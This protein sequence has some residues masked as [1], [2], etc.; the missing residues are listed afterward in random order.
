MVPLDTPSAAPGSRRTR[1][2]AVIHAELISLR[3]AHSG[4]DAAYYGDHPEWLIAVDL[5]SH[6]DA[7]ALTRSNY[8]VV[9][10]RLR[11]ADGNEETWCEESSSHWAVGWTANFAVAPGSGAE[12]VLRDAVAQLADYPVLD[13]EHYSELEFG[14]ASEYWD[15]LS[16]GLRIGDLA[17]NG[18]SIFAARADYINLLDR[19]PTTAERIRE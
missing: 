4:P 10:T 5:G 2:E 13:E 8:A 6:R 16:L 14:E 11:D 17:A 3:D 12:T 15:G 7:D 18:E 9:E 19:A 1:R